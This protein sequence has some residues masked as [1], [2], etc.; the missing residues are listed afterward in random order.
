M[1]SENASSNILKVRRFRCRSC[2]CWHVMAK[3]EKL[4]WFY[5]QKL[6]NALA[7]LPKSRRDEESWLLMM[8][9]IVVFLNNQ[10]NVVF[11]GLEEGSYWSNL[12]SI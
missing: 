3:L 11:Q 5:L 1:I 9:K 2:V 8:Q 12:V 6:S 7:L 4:T 10:L